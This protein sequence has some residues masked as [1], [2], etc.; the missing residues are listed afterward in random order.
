MLT[1]LRQSVLLLLDNKSSFA[2]V[3]ARV[4]LK[5]LD[6]YTNWVSPYPADTA[7]R[8]LPSCVY[9]CVRPTRMSALRGP[10]LMTGDPI[11][12]CVLANFLF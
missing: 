12:E 9:L 7:P 6:I 3:S 5:V 8:C 10:W 4:Y 2:C 1:L 11:V